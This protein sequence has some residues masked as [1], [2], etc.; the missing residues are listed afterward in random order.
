MITDFMAPLPSPAPLCASCFDLCWAPHHSKLLGL[1]P[2]LGCAFPETP[3]I[4]P[5]PPLSSTLFLIFPSCFLHGEETPR[6]PV[7]LQSRGRAVV[8]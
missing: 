2:G 5:Q 1:S 4:H 8:P 3:L 6:Q 7:G